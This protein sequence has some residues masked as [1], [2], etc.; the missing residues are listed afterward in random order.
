MNTKRLSGR[1]GG[2]D[3]ENGHLMSLLCQ[4]LTDFYSLAFGCAPQL[5]TAL[6]FVVLL[7]KA[8]NSDSTFVTD[9]IVGQVQ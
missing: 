1:F 5:Q 8:G 4:L 3:R 9:L 6:H 2:G 7:K